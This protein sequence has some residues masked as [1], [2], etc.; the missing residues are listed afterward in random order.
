MEI[1]GCPIKTI[2]SGIHEIFE[3]K[4]GQSVGSGCC[5]MG[6]TAYHYINTGMSISMIAFTLF[7][8]AYALKNHAIPKVTLHKN[9]LWAFAV[10]YACLFI[11]TLFHLD[12]TGNMYGGSYSF[13]SYV[14]I[15]LPL[16]MILYIGWEHDIR[17]TV[18]YT[19][20]TIGYA[21]CGYGIYEYAAKHMERLDSFYTSPPHVGIMMDVFIPLT[22]AFICYYRDNIFHL[23]VMSVLLVLEAVTLILTQTRGAMGALSIA[24]LLLC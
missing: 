15:P 5:R 17:K 22:I 1:Y 8:I 19:F 14:M 6:A 2:R 4:L 20:V 18:C 11:S 9:I 16:F 24:I 3:Y 23:A 10:F 12:N 21:I 7:V 13:L